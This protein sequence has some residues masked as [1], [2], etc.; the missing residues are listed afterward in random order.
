[1][2]DMLGTEPNENE[3]PP[4]LSDFSYEVQ[5]AVQVFGLLKDV[6]D[7]FG[8]NYMGKDLSIIFQI[9]EILEIEKTSQSLIFK[10]VQHLDSCRASLIKRKQDAK[11]SQKPSGK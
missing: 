7:P 10:I 9:F 5:Q 8:G 2:C 3:M 4:D 11:A 1:M 6:W